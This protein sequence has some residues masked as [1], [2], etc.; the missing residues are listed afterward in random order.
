[1]SQRPVLAMPA[2]VLVVA[3]AEVVVEAINN[4]NNNTGNNSSS[5]SSNNNISNSSSNRPIMGRL[6]LQQMC[7]T[8]S[9]TLSFYFQLLLSNKSFSLKLICLF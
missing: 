4:N 3:V 8:L 9:K 5:S 2:V 1:M 7:S 6:D